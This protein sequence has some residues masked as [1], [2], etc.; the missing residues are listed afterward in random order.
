MFFTKEDFAAKRSWSAED[1]ATWVNYQMAER[2][3]ER[4]ALKGDGIDIDFKP[5]LFLL[6]LIVMTFAVVYFG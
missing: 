2:I 5:S 4:D 6:I 3:R 1:L